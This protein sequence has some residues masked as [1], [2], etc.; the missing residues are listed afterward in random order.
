[1]GGGGLLQRGV[2]SRLK[3]HERGRGLC[4]LRR[5][6]P[7][8][9]LLRG[10]GVGESPVEAGAPVGFLTE[11]VLERGLAL[12]RGGKIGRGALARLLI[13]RF[14]FREHFVERSSDGEGVS[15]FVTVF[16]F[17][18]AEMLGRGGRVRPASLPRLV[19]RSGYDRQFS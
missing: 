15:Q 16:R 5:V 2:V 7:G 14:R 11:Q 17:A 4:L 9:L 1:M 13:R 10:F 8:R 3:L 19:E 12:G 18:L 6:P